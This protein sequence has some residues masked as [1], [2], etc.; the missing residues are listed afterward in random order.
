MSPSVDGR[1]PCGWI[2]LVVT[3]N[4]GTSRCLRVSAN[5][6]LATGEGRDTGGR[7]AFNA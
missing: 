1:A 2:C 7:A 3:D 6:E 4:T 5:G